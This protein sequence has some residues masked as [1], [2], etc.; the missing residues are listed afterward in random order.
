M[1]YSIID[2]VYVGNAD[3]TIKYVHFSNDFMKI[4]NLHK[5]LV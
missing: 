3:I 4:L 1:Q 5:Y 2:L